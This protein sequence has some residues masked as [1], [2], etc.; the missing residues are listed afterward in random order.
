MAGEKHLV[1]NIVDG[2]AVPKAGGGTTKWSTDCFEYVILLRI[3]AFWRSMTRTAFN[4]R[5]TP[6]HFGFNA[7]STHLVWKAGSRS[8]APVAELP[9]RRTRPRAMSQRSDPVGQSLRTAT[10]WARL[11]K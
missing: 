8:A 7:R 5:F 4:Q 9:A 10:R 3:H 11:E 2:V 6:L 1:N